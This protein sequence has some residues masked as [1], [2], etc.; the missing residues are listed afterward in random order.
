VF[1]SIENKPIE[2][3]LKNLEKTKADAKTNL[4]RLQNDTCFCNMT[5]DDQLIAFAKK[6]TALANTLSL[7]P[8]KWTY[9]R[10][11]RLT[12]EIMTTIGK[13]ILYNFYLFIVFSV[14]KVVAT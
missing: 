5:S 11:F 6:I 10:G 7:A 14:F 8:K 1:I 3:T 9:K 12:F 13:K 4:E 2:E